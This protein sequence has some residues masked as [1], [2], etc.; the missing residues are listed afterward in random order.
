MRLVSLIAFLSPD[1]SGLAIL[2]AA[3]LAVALVVVLVVAG[4]GWVVYR[5]ASGAARQAVIVAPIAAGGLLTLWCLVFGVGRGWLAPVIVSLLLMMAVGTV[6]IYPVAWSCLMLRRPASRR[7]RIAATMLL[8]SAIAGAAVSGHGVADIACV[9]VW[10]GISGDPRAFRA[11]M[12][13]TARDSGTLKWAAILLGTPDPREWVARNRSTPVDVLTVLAMSTGPG[14][15]MSSYLARRNPSIPLA[16]LTDSLGDVNPVIEWAVA[17]PPKIPTA[18]L[19]SL[20]Q[21][22][23][24]IRS[25][26][27]YHV[28]YVRE[29]AAPSTLRILSTDGS[30]RT[31]E[32]VARSPRAPA[33]VLAAMA[34]DSSLA[35][36]IAV[37][38]SPHTP[39]AALAELVRDTS[40]FVRAGLAHRG[41]RIP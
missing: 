24:R 18:T 37:A 39:A 25:G 4:G 21:R 32:A 23:S 33:D 9:R 29:R 3:G 10:A 15:G 5:G 20:A 27:G 34:H 16:V 28:D 7:A 14:N 8:T 11:L 2:F 26:L 17:K 1:F 31:R 13:A 35:V 41:V 6:L 22:F 38:W 12:A 30:E 36:R 40:A 19:D